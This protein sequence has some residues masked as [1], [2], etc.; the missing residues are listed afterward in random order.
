MELEDAG[1]KLGRVWSWI[2]EKN[3]GMDGR[4]AWLIGKVS[5]YAWNILM[6]IRARYAAEQVKLLE[7]MERKGDGGSFRFTEQH[8]LGQ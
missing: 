7:Y 6:K 2:R 1:S 8:F 5:F 4:I 3:A